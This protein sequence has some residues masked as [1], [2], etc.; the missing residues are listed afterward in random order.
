MSCIYMHDDWTFGRV[1]QLS[2]HVVE[3]SNTVELHYHGKAPFPALVEM[4]F[5][6]LPFSGC[7]EPRFCFVSSKT[8]LSVRLFESLLHIFISIFYLLFKNTSQHLCKDTLLNR[9][10]AHW[11]AAGRFILFFSFYLIIPC[12][13][14]AWSFDCQWTEELNNQGLI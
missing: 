10:R 5:L 2:V 9:E 13:T 6:K 3:V 14:K 8:P 4:V 12:I 7:R 1:Q 11:K